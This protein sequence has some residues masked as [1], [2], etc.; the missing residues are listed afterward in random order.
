MPSVFR[1]QPNFVM[2]FNIILLHYVTGLLIKCICTR[3]MYTCLYFLFKD[4]TLME[5]ADKKWT[6]KL[7]HQLQSIPHSIRAI[8]GRLYCCHN[9]GISIYD[10]NFTPIDA[11]LKQDMGCFFD[12]VGLWG[13]DL[14]V[15]CEKG[16][17]HINHGGKIWKISATDFTKCINN[18]M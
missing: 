13:T 9:D 10:S 16:L 7:Q 3:Y 6:K 8:N 11:I 15:A 18:Y 4:K 1:L 12:V 14:V 2:L 17:F 5:Y